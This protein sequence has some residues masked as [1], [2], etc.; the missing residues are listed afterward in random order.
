MIA[1][2]GVANMSKRAEY[3]DIIFM[4]NSKEHYDKCIPCN[5]NLHFINFDNPSFGSKPYITNIK[6][7]TK[8]DWMNELTENKTINE[9]LKED[10]NDRALLTENKFLSYIYKIVTDEKNRNVRSF[11]LNYCKKCQTIYHESYTVYHK[12]LGV[13]YYYHNVI[14]KEKL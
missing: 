6:N 13:P 9:V 11:S 3:P 8:T 14:E 4:T 2:A 12:F 5:S 1:A 10:D 7:R